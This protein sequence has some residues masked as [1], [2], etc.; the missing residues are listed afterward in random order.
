MKKSLCVILCVALIFCSTSVVIRAEEEAVAY[1]WDGHPLIF[2][3]GYSGPKLIRDRGLETE[4]QVWSI[5]PPDLAKKLITNLFNIISSIADY[6]EGDVEPFIECFREVSAELLDDISMLPDGSSKYNITSYPHYPQESTV[7]YITTVSGKEYLP[8]TEGEFIEDLCLTIPA[9]QIFIFNADW[10]RSQIDNCEHLSWYI[11]EVRKLTGSNQVD[12]YGMSHGGQLAATYLFYHGTEGKVD[13]AVLN[14]PAIGGTT[15]V[16]ELLGSEPIN[17]DMNE[18]LRFAGIMLHT[19]IDLRWLGNILPAEFLNSLVK[20]AFNEVM[21]P[22]AIY[23]G[24][25]WDL[26]D[27][28][29]YKVLR[30]VYLDPVENADIIAKADKMHFECIPNMGEGLRKAQQ[31]GVSISILSNYGTHIGTGKAIDSDFI[32]DTENI[33]GATVATFG[34]HFDTDYVQ[35]NTSCTDPTHN[36]ISPT[37][38]VDA[39]TCFLPENTWF[40]YEQYHTQS[41]WDK[42]TRSLLLELLLTDNIKDVHSDSRYP[43]FEIAQSPLDAVYVK[44]T[45][46]ASGFYNEQSDTLEITNISGDTLEILSVTVN[47]RKLDISSKLKIKK[48]ACAKIACSIADGEDLLEMKISYRRKGKPVSYTHLTLPTMAVV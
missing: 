47:G 5:D 24:S 10:R 33:S 17:F 16:T 26:M 1:E 30:D 25:V 14:S 11:D 35:L 15:L 29:S 2:I 28:D 37:Q 21:L 31:A 3:Q 43:Q 23:F 39:S 18:L 19:E 36:H 40:N 38:T 46:E 48:G 7:E 32:I 20:T 9:D 6:A 4:E 22:Y 12:I 45:N 8:M 44:F 34:E 27:T 42:Y 13:N 41:W